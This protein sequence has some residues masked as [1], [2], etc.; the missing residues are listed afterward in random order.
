MKDL[1]KEIN[2][3]IEKHEEL[4]NDPSVIKGDRFD[5]S[6]TIEADKLKSTIEDVMKKHDADKKVDDG[7]EE[8]RDQMHK[9]QRIDRDYAN[10][11]A[12][13][14]KTYLYKF[15][16]DISSADESKTNLKNVL[17]SLTFRNIDIDGGRR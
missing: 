2:E 16:T 17:S 8:L 12:N 1:D 15:G 14:D 3:K 11:D 4:E 5:Y 7:M 10:S 9:L 6:E 13:K